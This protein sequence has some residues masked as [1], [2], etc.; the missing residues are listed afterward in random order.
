M[1]G[2]WIDPALTHLCFTRPS[3]QEGQDS[4][5]LMHRVTSYC[6]PIDPHG[7]CLLLII[8]VIWINIP[9]SAGPTLTVQGL[10]PL[11]VGAVVPLLEFQFRFLLPCRWVCLQ[12][13]A[14]TR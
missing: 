4:G 9:S 12:A 10:V 2:V 5:S 3:S 11:L 8:G 13:P 6:G 7:T 14:R 1:D